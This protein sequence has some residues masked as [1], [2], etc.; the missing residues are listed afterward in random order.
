MLLGI[1]GLFLVLKPSRFLEGFGIIKSGLPFLISFLISTVVGVVYGFYADFTPAFLEARNLLLPL[2]ALGITSL[3][4]L[5]SAERFLGFLIFFAAFL[6]LPGIWELMSGSNIWNT[7]NRWDLLRDQFRI[8][9]LVGHPTDYGYLIYLT[10][11][12]I[13]SALLNNGIPKRWIWAA[14]AVSVLSIYVLF[15]TLSKGPIIITLGSL[16]TISWRTKQRK[17]IIIFVLLTGI[18]LFLS[19]VDAIFARFQILM[20]SLSGWGSY[21]AYEFSRQNTYFQTIPVFLDFPI[22]GVGPGLYGSW[23]ATQ[24]FSIVHSIYGIYTFGAGSLDVLFLTIIGEQGLVGILCLAY[25]FLKLS[26]VFSQDNTA[27]T[28][29]AESLFVSAHAL[30]L[31][32]LVSMFFSNTGISLVHMS[33]FWSIIGVSWSARTKRPT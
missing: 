17:K 29:L 19:S 6:A 9:G 18:I 11:I 10:T 27:A 32:I 1:G 22:F 15:Q 25:F 3:S 13:L 30:S 8:H 16:L 26:S 12:P 23:V 4:N 33:L 20:E 31:G 14:W 5:N 7:L 28:P 2:L 24:Y 21:D